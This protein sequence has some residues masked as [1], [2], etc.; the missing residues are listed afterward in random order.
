MLQR[1]LLKQWLYFSLFAILLG[2]SSCQKE[3]PLLE[4]GQDKPSEVKGTA[5]LKANVLTDNEAIE[6]AM[7][8]Y[9]LLSKN[10]FRASGMPKVKNVVRKSLGE[11]FRS[12]QPQDDNAGVLVVSF[13]DDRGFMLLSENKYG[14]PVLG[15]VARGNFD[16]ILTSNPQFEYLFKRVQLYAFSQNL[17]I[18]PK[19]GDRF[20]E[21]V[22]NCSPDRCK[23]SETF[24]VQEHDAPV[25]YTAK[26][27]S[28]P[29]LIN[30][31]KPLLKVNWGQGAPYNNK[32]PL[33][34]LKGREGE[35]QPVGCVATAVGQ[36]MSHY[37]HPKELDWDAL[38]K[39]DK[40]DP[41][42]IEAVSTLL[43][44]L[45]DA[46]LLDMDY[47]PDGSGAWSSNVPRTLKAYGYECSTLID[48]DINSIIKEL[49]ENR[50]VYIASQRPNPKDPEDPI[51]HAYVLDGYRT[52]ERCVKYY[53]YRKK[54][55]GDYSDMYP[56][57]YNSVL[58]PEIPDGMYIQK[59]KEEEKTETYVHFNYG[60]DGSQ[61]DYYLS[62][63]FNIIKMP[64]PGRRLSI[65]WAS[66]E[67]VHDF[68]YFMN[69]KM[70][71]NIQ[72]L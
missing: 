4:E 65:V 29:I 32:V 25:W 42:F 31:L 35:T 39:Q 16:K 59:D 69:L 64:R 46:E 72:P 9:P 60:W 10:E 28:Q 1:N 27:L 33:S 8:Y 44:K 56:E 2:F 47:D 21:G 6:R 34:K 26:E 71:I 38:L 40:S 5:T 62:D 52:L 12:T 18:C 53:S 55:A 48:Y 45:G 51:G 23:L 43:Y 67:E 30:E 14:T 41:K 17:S 68:R 57:S 3:M 63:V 61:N 50:V 36:I 58:E 24:R 13:E 11:S 22:G 15:A 37:K 20:N 19:C 54:L 7:Q 49:L 66:N 70:I